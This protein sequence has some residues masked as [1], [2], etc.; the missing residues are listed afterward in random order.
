MEASGRYYTARHRAIGSRK[1][2]LGVT[3]PRMDDTEL[4]RRLN[5]ILSQ[6]GVLERKVDFLFEHLG[7]TYVDT[8]PQ[9]DE[10]EKLILADDGIGAIKLYQQ[11]R[12]VNLLDAKRAVEE[13]KAKLGL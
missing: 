4:Y 13:I 9:R 10:I 7:V 6:V 1:A 8:P 11:K 5:A 12:K 3:M 2:T